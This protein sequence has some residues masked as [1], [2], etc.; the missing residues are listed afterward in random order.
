M[1]GEKEKR[2]IREISM[3]DREI[4]DVRTSCICGR[5]FVVTKNKMNGAKR[6]EKVPL[7]VRRSV[8]MT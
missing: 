8:F 4:H 5:K 3:S 7:L 6:V 2:K 1:M